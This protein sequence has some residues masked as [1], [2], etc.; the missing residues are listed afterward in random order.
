[1]GLYNQTLN[2]NIDNVQ[3]NRKVVGGSTPTHTR[4][5]L[6]EHLSGGNETIPIDKQFNEFDEI[7]FVAYRHADNR[8]YLL[9]EKIFNTD[10]LHVNDFIQIHGGPN[11]PEYVTYQL[12][13]ANTFTLSASGS[14]ILVTRKVYGVKY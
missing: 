1:M 11:S 7:V 14:A 2:E 5:L 12:T 4:E 13:D 8:T 3:V 9:A 10:N 6:Y